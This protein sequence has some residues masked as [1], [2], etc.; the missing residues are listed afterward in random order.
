MAHLPPSGAKQA[1]GENW[2]TL[3]QAVIHNK[4]Q[5]FPKKFPGVMPRNGSNTFG[6][7][8]AAYMGMG[9]LPGYVSSVPKSPV[10]PEDCQGRNWWGLQVS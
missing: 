5:I 3:P 9:C 4:C 7:K 2:E 6:G 10:C 1:L 8:N